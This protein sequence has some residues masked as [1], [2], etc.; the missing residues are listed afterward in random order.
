MPS[1]PPAAAQASAKLKAAEGA[2][3]AAARGALVSEALATL[4]R[5]PLACN[6]EYLVSQLAFLR[7]YEVRTCEREA[8]APAQRSA[9]QLVGETFSPPEL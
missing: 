6:L 2:P 8:P 4:S 3:N 1:Y 9:V 7:C 5:V